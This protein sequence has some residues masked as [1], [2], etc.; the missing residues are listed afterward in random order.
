MSPRVFVIFL[1]IEFGE[2]LR[3]RAKRV[4]NHAA[5]VEPSLDLPDS[6]YHDGEPCYK[7]NIYLEE[8]LEEMK[9]TVTASRVSPSRFIDE[10]AD[11]GG[12]PRPDNG[13]RL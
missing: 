3:R 4:M 13:R 7:Q 11:Y 9:S 6:V 10:R 1:Q 8:S 12:T 5:D 2:R